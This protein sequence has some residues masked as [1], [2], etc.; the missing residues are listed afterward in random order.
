MQLVYFGRHN[1]VVGIYLDVFVHKLNFVGFTQ[2]AKRNGWMRTSKTLARKMAGIDS[3]VR[4]E[5]LLQL[6]LPSLPQFRVRQ[7]DAAK[8]DFPNNHVDVVFS[9]AVF[10]HLADPSAVISEIRRV[11]KPNGV[12]FLAL[13]LF[14]SHSGCHDTRIFVGDRK[15]LPFWAHL[16]AGT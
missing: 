12:M 13:H 6:G 1:E 5:L 4:K 16:R 3:R 10:E 14:S 2:M 9:R 15:E 7:M 8:M 11:L